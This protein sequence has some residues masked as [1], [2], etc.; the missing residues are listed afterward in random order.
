MFFNVDG[1]N[2]KSEIKQQYDIVII[3]GG[4]AGIAAA[5][6]AL[7]GGASALVI[8]KAVEGGQMNLTD[9]IEN[10]PGFKTIKGEELSTLMKEHAVHFGADF[11][12]GKVVE[13]KDEG[14]NKMVVMENGKTIKSKAIIIASGSNPRKLGVKGEKEFSSKGV[15][16]CASCDGHFFKNKKIAVV[17]GGNTAVEEAVY[18]SNIAKE[19]YIIHRREKLRADKLYQDRAFSRNNIKFKW[20]SVIEEIKGK[21]K[22][23]SLVIKNLKNG[24]VYEEL[25]DGVFVFVGLVPE[26]S[27]LN[28]DLFEFDE[29]GFLITDENMETKVKGIYAVGDVRKK[30]LR[31]IVTAVS[32]GAI[33]A[34]HAIREYINE[35]QIPSTA[36]IN[37]TK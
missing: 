37:L 26:T 11:Y 19:V 9:I 33:A 6:Y 12:D 20:N 18:L 5:I 2:K 3:G 35:D 16:Y 15:S 31:Q 14:P 1:V 30:E 7:Q 25:F 22:V 28:K 10:Y 23:E 34:S 24:E 32:D 27:F 4:P 13:L 29:Y 17:G 21:D 36:S 8:E